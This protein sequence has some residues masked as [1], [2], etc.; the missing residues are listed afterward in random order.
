MLDAALLH[1]H[2]GEG[3]QDL[4]VPAAQSCM[5]GS[6][7]FIRNLLNSKFNWLQVIGRKSEVIWEICVV[8]FV[9]SEE[10]LHHPIL[11]TQRCPFSRCIQTA[12]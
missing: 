9:N 1:Q 7:Y 5:S 6:I 3:A 12:R 2:G 11:P 10:E 8:A 4:Y